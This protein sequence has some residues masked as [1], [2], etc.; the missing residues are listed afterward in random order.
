MVFLARAY[1]F[2]FPC[3]LCA[4][5]RIRRRI[6]V[7]CGGIF[8]IRNFGRFGHRLAEQDGQVLAALQKDLRH[9]G[10]EHLGK[11]FTSRLGNALPGSPLADWT[12]VGAKPLPQLFQCQHYCAS[13]PPDAAS[14]VNRGSFHAKFLSRARSGLS[15]RGGR[16]I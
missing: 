3:I 7:R 6:D 11:L 4:N 15:H 9:G 13:Q 10:A 5:E 12:A 8:F 1:G 16:Q 2:L 14:D